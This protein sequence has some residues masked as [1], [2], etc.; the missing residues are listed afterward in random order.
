MAILNSILRGQLKGRLGSVYFSH[1]RNSK[2]Q[3]V[4]RAGTVNSSPS[5]PKTYAQ[6][7]QRARF[8]NAVKFYTR[9]TQNF[10]RFAYE[11]K[12][13]NETDYNAFM[14]YNIMRSLVLPK[15]S[16]N[17]AL[18]PA[19]GDKWQLSQ[20]SL[21]FAPYGVFIDISSNI[22]GYSLAINVKTIG[23]ISSFL[24][25]HVGVQPGDIYTVVVIGSNVDKLNYDTMDD[26]DY[27]PSWCVVQFV[28]D[29]SSETPWED[30]PKLSN[31]DWITAYITA[32]N[33]VCIYPRFDCTSMWAT[34]IVTR[35]SSTGLR[36]TTSFLRPNVTASELENLFRGTTNINKNA[37]TWGAQDAAILKGG[38]ATRTGVSDSDS[39]NT[40]SSFSITSVDGSSIP[41]SK[42]LSQNKN[43]T[44]KIVGTG[45]VS[46]SPV[47][48]NSS[49]VSIESFTVNSSKTE[50][51]L[52]IKGLEGD[53]TAAI[54]Y[55]GVT[56]INASVN[57]DA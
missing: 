31:E 56:I 18:F 11:D 49:A 20:G 50:A 5:N 10:F 2:G 17:N 33:D 22:Q 24:M 29:P 3:P 36:A 34:E 44:V 43:V 51:S 27:E 4:T 23:S 14:R 37:A 35:K 39:G 55:N 40:S 21:S 8:A 32:T 38:V 7:I 54:T 15:D 46:T 30:V 1:A 28:I 42:L 25:S 41:V 6:M 48:S 9:A 19:L 13:A 52:I 47:S 16:V 53:A 45:L 57:T 12:K 26:V